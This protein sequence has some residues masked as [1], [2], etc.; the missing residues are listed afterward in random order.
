MYAAKLTLYILKQYKSYNM[1]YIY[2]T[3]KYG[4]CFV[5]LKTCDVGV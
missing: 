3:P 1:V 5:Q 2:V 4:T